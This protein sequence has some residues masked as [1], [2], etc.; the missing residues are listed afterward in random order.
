M[1]PTSIADLLGCARKGLGVTDVI[2]SESLHHAVKL[3]IAALPFLL[4]VR[5]VTGHLSPAEIEREDSDQ[6]YAGILLHWYAEFASNPALCIDSLTDFVGSVR[7]TVDDQ[8]TGFFER[9]LYP[10]AQSFRKRNQAECDLCDSVMLKWLSAV[11]S[12]QLAALAVRWDQHRRSNSVPDILEE[13]GLTKRSMMDLPETEFVRLGLA[14]RLDAEY[15]DRHAELQ[16]FL[17]EDHIG[18]EVERLIFCVVNAFTV[19]HNEER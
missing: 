14:E 3:L 10:I 2:S 13:L 17:R 8:I 19:T 16:K 11:N 7:C 5:I 1:K 18:N 9:R 15:R 4:P 12:D 6:P